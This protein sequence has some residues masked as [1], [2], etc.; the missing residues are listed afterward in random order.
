M[1]KYNELVGAIVIYRQQVRPFTD[2]QIE[3]VK[4]FA[5]Q[6]VI[7][8]DNTR[9]LNELR[10]S[11]EQQT[12]T[13]DVLSVISSSP[14]E[15][16]PVFEAMLANGTR[17]CEAKFGTLFLYEGGGL[18]F[19]AG[20]NV[21]SAFAQK[22]RR[23]P[24]HPAPGG[25]IAEAIRTKQTV[26]VADL[27]ATRGYAERRPSVVDAVEL[28]GIRTT[29]AVPMLKDDEL[30]GIIII[31]RQ[32]VRPFTEKQIALLTSFASQAVIAIENARLLNELRQRTDDLG[33]SLEQQTATSEVLRVISGSPGELEPV[34]QAMLANGTQLCEA[35]FG[36]LYLHDGGTLRIV[37]SYNV[38]PAFTEAQLKRGPFHPAPDS[39]LGEVVRTKQAAQV[40]DLAATQRYAERHPV[41]VAAVELGGVRTTVNVPMLKDN[42]LIGIISIFRQEVRPFT[43]KQ[44]ALLT[45][46][47]SQAVIAIENARL[48]NEL[49][50]SLQQQT[51]TADVLKVISRSTFDLEAVLNTL[52]ESAA[53]LCGA[54]RAA[55]RLARDGLFHHVASYG[56]TPGQ[57]EYMIEHPVPAKPDRGYIAG[58]VMSEG[59]AVQIED[60]KADPEFRFL[61]N[62]QSGFANVRTMLGVRRNADRCP[63]FNAKH[64]AAIH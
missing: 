46:F 13:S 45:N 19:V 28:G 54:D 52:V 26:Q 42:E 62:V 59:K 17:L 58:R 18:H 44:I 64:R 36:N 7:A 8:I 27:A 23:D 3:L 53:R 57:R 37:A 29:V 49:R 40:A 14:G 48:L 5:N 60:A 33:E 56:F 24:L 55:I 61:T 22:R 20:H 12:A 25:H 31:Y 34:F 6:A 32:E 43:D 50:E 35:K 30:I 39:T 63:Y 47:A 41:T 1:L 21:P 9:L 10:E 11:L 38:P 4:S 16:E 51:A 15:L 2:K